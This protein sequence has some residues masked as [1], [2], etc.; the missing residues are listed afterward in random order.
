MVGPINQDVPSRHVLVDGK[1]WV[2]VVDTD[3][4]TTK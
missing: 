3:N 1:L 4:S 2:P